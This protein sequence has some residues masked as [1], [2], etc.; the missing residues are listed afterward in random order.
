VR[1][2]TERG[3]IRT[4]LDDPSGGTFD[5]AGDFDRLLPGLTNEDYPMLRYV[6]RYGYTIFNR[7]QMDPLIAELKRLL[8]LAEPGS[9]ERGLRRLIAMAEQCRLS[10]HHYLWFDGD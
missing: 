4:G 9:E 1:L 6:D 5:A 2:K 3:E 7:L 8:P 10:V